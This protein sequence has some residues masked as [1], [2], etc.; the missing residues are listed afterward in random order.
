MSEVKMEKVTELISSAVKRLDCRFTRLQY[1]FSQTFLNETFQES[2]WIDCKLITHEK[3]FPVSKYVFITN[4]D[5]STQVQRNKI[6]NFYYKID[7][8]CRCL[9]LNHSSTVKSVATCV[10]KKDGKR[11]YLGKKNCETKNI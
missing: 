4:F 3:Q 5:I 1:G 11:R 6:I 8:E 9:I 10:R 2:Y 7:S